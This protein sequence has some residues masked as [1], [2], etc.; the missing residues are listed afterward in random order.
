MTTRKPNDELDREYLARQAISKLMQAMAG[1]DQMA[2][3]L[4]SLQL[5]PEAQ[6]AVEECLATA[7]REM[8]QAATNITDSLRPKKPR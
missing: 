1:I 7:R 8:E 2:D 3:Q 5:R 4:E 6:A